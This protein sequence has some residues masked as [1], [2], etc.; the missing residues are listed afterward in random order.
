MRDKGGSEQKGREAGIH[1]LF[2]EHQGGQH[3]RALPPN[4]AA[5][6]HRCL[7]TLKFTEIEEEAAQ[8]LCHVSHI[9]RAWTALES[10]LPSAQKEELG[11]PAL[12]RKDSTRSLGQ[13][14]RGL[15]TVPSG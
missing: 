10:P 7:F 4:T 6:S 3:V 11:G 9:S 1:S 13:S 15:G 14:R 5:P 8:S 2:E 12:E